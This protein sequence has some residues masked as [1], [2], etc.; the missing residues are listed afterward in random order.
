MK[1]SE[2]TGNLQRVVYSVFLIALIAGAAYVFKSPARVEAQKSEKTPRSERLATATFPTSTGLPL[3]IPDN[4]TAGT[5][6]TIPV[7]GLTDEVRGVA[8]NFSITHTWAG[9]LVMNL[10]EPG[11]NSHLIFQR[12]GSTSG[13]SGG[14]SSD[15][16]GPYTFTDGTTGDFWMTA[17]TTIGGTVPAGS[18]RTLA[19]CAP[20]VSGPG[21][22]TDMNPV[23]Q[24]PAFADPRAGFEKKGGGEGGKPILV[25]PPDNLGNGNWTVSIE[26]QVAGDTGSLTAL[27]LTITTLA[28][29]AALASIRGAVRTGKGRPISGAFVTILNTE[30]NESITVRTGTFGVFRFED[31]PVGVFYT[32]WVEHGRYRFD[33]PLQSFTLLDDLGTTFISSR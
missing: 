14:D 8:L 23:F 31:L 30:T 24:G 21:I 12:V 25:N 19:C 9:D 15:L 6:A 7:S 33:Q 4:D 20:A 17:G 2:R 13:T 22:F 3:A 1:Q 27:S 28:P 32:M 16:A 18:Y 10:T 11:A 29:T 5:T 26:D